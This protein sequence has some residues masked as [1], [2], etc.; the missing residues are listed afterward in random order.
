MRV[1]SFSYKKGLP[2]DPSGNGGGFL[3]DCRGLNNPGRL[4]LYKHRTGNDIVVQEFLRKEIL[5]SEF[6]QYAQGL[7]DITLRTYL[8][9]GFTSLMVGFG[10]TGGQHRSVYCANELTKWLQ[11]RYPVRVLLCHRELGSR[12]RKAMILAA[13]LG[14]RLRPLTNGKPKA[15]VE[16]GG[17]PLLELQIL[18]LKAL[19]FDEVVV[20]VHHHAD[21]VEEF[22]QT[23]G[24]FGITVH[25]SDER[26]A[27]L[28]TGGALLKARRHLEG[29][30]PFYVCNVDVLTDLDPHELAPAHARAG[31][32]ATLAVRRRDTAR[33]LCFDDGM[34]MCGWRNVKTG[35][36][37]GAPKEDAKLLAFS[38][39]HVIDP[40]V[41][42]HM[43]RKGVFSVIDLYLDLMR[44]HKIVGYVHDESTWL[45]V[46]RP[47]HLAEAEGLAKA[48][49]NGRA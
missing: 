32:L 3:F 6:L 24:N 28:N 43:E 21:M 5:V 17:V 16:V 8:A 38:G 1:Q 44:D 25:I 11:R 42:K 45:D 40:I 36:E 20:N 30:A 37:K 31:A 41:F 14:T 39:L 19:G 22:L 46:G 35:E 9:R 13:G 18:R 27:L 4:K 48:I 47:V 7:V 33:Y 49:L 23:R 26:S 12:M 10:C 34:R 2:A 29:S 15:L